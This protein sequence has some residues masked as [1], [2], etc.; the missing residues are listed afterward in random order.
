MRMYDI[1][2]KKRDGKNLTKEEIRFFINGYTNG[3]IPDYQTSALLM[4][5]FFQDM[6]AAERAELT[7][8]MVESGDQIDLS[9]ISGLKVDKHSTGGVGDT[10][11]LILA[12]LVASAGVPV[13]KMSGRG[14]GHT[15]G[16][17][18]KLEAVPG[19]H[20]EISSDEFINLV[21][22]NKV[23]VVGQT[24]NLTPADKKLYSLRD[25][26]ATV[27]SIPLIAS[28]IMSKKIASGSDAI[29]LDVKT[30]AG[31]FMKELDD[32]RELAQA[33]VSI[34]NRVGR[35][36]MAVISDM[37]QPLGYAVG[38]ALEVR[39]AID[40]LQGNGP[41]DLTEL[42]LE[43]GSQMVVLANKANTLDEARKQLT[44]NL[45]TGKAIEQFKL[46]LE[47]QGGDSRVI[48][49][50]DLL[51]QAS[52]TF[53]LPAEKSGTISKISADDIGNSAMMLGAGRATKESAIDLSVGLVLHKKIGD[54]VNHGESLLTI[55]AN[56]STIEDV[57]ET[58]YQS[59]VISDEPVKNPPLI[60]ENITK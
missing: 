9:A 57:K 24:G 10:T 3:D 4:A 17:I 21:N 14:L 33:M 19:F 23:A 40:T 56:T 55:H 44:D 43:L 8:A 18:D 20:V 11:T 5:V 35:N 38:N 1:I 12:P 16:T 13:A 2:E 60:Y 59:I 48:D 53:E 37:S 34:G 6:T 31:A 45:N 22:Q 58:L 29:V 28:S 32:A 42:C 27:N 26:T 47:S 30:G 51:P 41:D 36:T 54:Y 39:E 25:V 52:H 7:S 15:G 49:Q 50:P 46:F